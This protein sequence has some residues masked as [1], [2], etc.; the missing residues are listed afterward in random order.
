MFQAGRR[1]KEAGSFLNPGYEIAT[2]PSIKQ[3]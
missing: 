2:E 3:L 1:K